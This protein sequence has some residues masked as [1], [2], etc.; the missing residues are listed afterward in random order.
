M[1]SFIDSYACL[2]ECLLCLATI[3]IES[4]LLLLLLPL[5]TLTRYTL[6]VTR[7]AASTPSPTRP[8]DVTAPVA[9]T[10]SG[11]PELLTQE[12]FYKCQ[13]KGKCS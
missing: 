7:R 6:T 1:A 3:A 13:R 2:A 10:V 11:P 9:R 5:G 4:L 8:A 12:V